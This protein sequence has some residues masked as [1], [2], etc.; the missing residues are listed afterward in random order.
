M[1]VKLNKII[2]FFS[3]IFICAG[4]YTASET[5]TICGNKYDIYKHTEYNYEQRLNATFNM[6]YFHNTKVFAFAYQSAGFRDNDS[7]LV[8]TILSH[9]NDSLIET[10]YFK[11][12]VFGHPYQSI[13]YFKCIKNGIV[14]LNSNIIIT[15]KTSKKRKNYFK[16]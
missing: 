16:K 11:D 4:C 5:I 2:V 12:N 9:R 10:T 13:R 14:S 3:L 6:L 8:Y 7:N 15:K 1:G